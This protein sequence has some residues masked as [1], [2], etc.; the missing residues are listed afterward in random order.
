[1][2]SRLPIARFRLVMAAGALACAGALVPPTG[3]EAQASS[4]GTA[5]HVN[6]FA[7]GTATMTRPDDITTLGGNIFAAY[8]NGIGPKGQAGPTGA[9][10]SVIVE[11]SPSGDQL[12]SWRVVGHCDGLT[13]DPPNNRLVATTNEDGNSS[14]YVIHP[15]TDQLAHYTYDISV[16]PHGGGTDAISFYQGHMLISASAPTAGAGPAVYKV[17]LFGSIAYVTPLFGDESLASVANTGTAASGKLVRLHLTDPDSNEVVP[18]ASPRF[19]GDFVLDS[20][21]D[22]EQV[23]VQRTDLHRPFWNPSLSVLR[24]PVSINDT[25]WATSTHGTLYATDNKANTIYAVSGRWR[26]G[27]ALV[28]VTP[29]AANVP[30]SAPGYLGTLNMFTAAITPLITSLQPGGLLFVPSA[31][32]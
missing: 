7:R 26:L 25:A 18:L 31:R 22:Q 1:M 15:S 28:A 27:E 4:P 8:Q 17:S 23:Y 13:A 21:G 2:I 12:A 30:S 24:L 11:Y 19:A 16:L 32:P 3:A 5:L 20:Q 6:V 14:L 10:D 29:A 9:T